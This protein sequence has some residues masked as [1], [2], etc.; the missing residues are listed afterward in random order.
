MPWLGGGVGMEL[1]FFLL[2]LLL[3]AFPIIAI[4][5]LVKSVGLAEHLRRLEARLAVL[6]RGVAGMPAPEPVAPIS[7]PQPETR[8][9]EAP[10]PPEREPP[11]AAF[12]PIAS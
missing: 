8:P 6:E 10:V 2:G 9:E 4:T 12:S 7:V 1:F 3:L 5:A 11:L